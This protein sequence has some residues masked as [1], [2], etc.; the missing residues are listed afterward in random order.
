MKYLG[1]R[2]TSS[3]WGIKYT[4]DPVDTLVAEAKQMLSTSSEKT[5]SLLKLEVSET[6]ITVEAMPQNSN[7][8]FPVG[9]F[10]IES[11]SYGVQDLVYTRVFAMITVNPETTKD[12][13]SIRL[14]ELSK[15]GNGGSPYRCHAFVTDTRDTAKNLT[16]ALAAA[17]QK[18]SFKVAAG[19]V[20]VPKNKQ[21]AIELRSKDTE[22]G[23]DSSEA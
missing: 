17:F 1:A 15:F 10:P 21:F 11:I 6:G 2:E 7:P 22:R 23:Q 3:L 19:K 16:L 18:F 4:R 9:T 5:L 14:S 8:N 12:S 13:Q 20:K